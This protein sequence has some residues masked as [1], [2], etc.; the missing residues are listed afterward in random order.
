MSA[1]VTTFDAAPMR[2][3][4]QRAV[5][6]DLLAGV[7]C[8]VLAGRETAA[9][10]CT[11]WADR[12]RGIA[13]REDHL[14]RAFSDTKLVTTCAA[15]LLLEAGHFGLDDPIERFIPALAHRRVLR[16]GATAI[17]DTEPA[18]GPITIRHLLTHTAGLSYGLFDPGT[19]IYSAYRA[20]RV[21]NPLTPLSDMI[22]QLAP[23]PL[24]FQPGA[25]WEYSV[26]TDVLGRLVEVVSGERFDV[27]LEARI[28]EPLGM[29]DTGFVIPQAAQDRLVAYY[30]GADPMDPTKP[31]LTRIDDQPYPQAYLR[32]APRLSGGGGLVSSL[33]DMT[34]LLRSLM[35]GGPTLL[36]PETLHTMMRN[37]LA[38]GANI[39]FAMLGDI[40]GKGF[41]LG[42]AITVAPSP[43][44]PADSAG[45]FQW[46]GLAGTHWWISPRHGLAG[47]LMAQ[48]EMGFWNPFS[49]EVKRAIWQ[50]AGVG[51]V[52]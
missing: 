10:H 51:G 22:E 31:G 17:D 23:L 27:F 39:R 18:N 42:G 15:L 28:F 13:L 3:A 44:D 34:A 2:A 47:V 52:G 12:E 30:R 49:F 5:D 46:G 41:G 8:A 24:V 38:E 6:A 43:V 19:P 37:Q 25:G 9:V 11:G 26:A 21:L 4:M 20:A 36:R 45:E 29:A 16:A 35:P 1:S 14:F 40:R 48:R 33:H 50:G 7:S 32:P